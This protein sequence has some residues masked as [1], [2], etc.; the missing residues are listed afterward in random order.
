MRQTAATIGAATIGVATILLAGCSPQANRRRHPGRRPS[1]HRTRPAASAPV[2]PAPSIEPASP[3]GAEW[4]PVPPQDSVTGTQ[5]Q[6]V[7]WTGTRF[8]ATGVALGAEGVFL[9]SPDGK[10]WHRQEG[11]AKAAYPIAIA[12][13]PAGVVAVGTIGDRRASWSSPDGLSWTARPDAFPAS[14]TG[15][16][17]VQITG[18]VSTGDGWIAVGR[19]DPACNF[20]CGVAPVRSLV[21]TSRDGLHWTSLGRQPSLVGAGMNGVAAGGPGYVAAGMGPGRAAIWTSADGSAWSQVPDDAM[22][23]PEAGSDP[24]AW[25]SGVGVASGHGVSVVVGWAYGVGPGGEPA[26]VAWWSPDGRTWMPAPVDQ[27]PGGQVFSVATTP[28][29]FLATGPSG[30]P[31]CLGGIWA[32]T[33]GRAWQC[34][35]S[36]PALKGFGPYAAAGSPTTEIAVGLTS[37]GEESPNGLPGAV[38]WRPIP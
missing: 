29:G 37:A 38:W 36:D 21:W 13:G 24:G 7:A 15:S 22:F 23:H 12:A 3:A 11:T 34:V 6:A 27:G 10:A 19:E 25:V 4:L 17:T 30:E 31:S 2:S 35:A 18:V 16:D 5:F 26:V 20:N 14:V 33:D 28:A 32:S 9:D 8:V 1:R